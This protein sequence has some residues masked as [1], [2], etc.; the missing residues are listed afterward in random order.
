MLQA[1]PS[2]I[3]GKIMVYFP[4]VFFLYTKAVL[5]KFVK[6][7][8]KHPKSMFSKVLGPGLCKNTSDCFCI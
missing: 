7:T 8:G 5:K 1:L 3:S 2:E 4:I 6:F